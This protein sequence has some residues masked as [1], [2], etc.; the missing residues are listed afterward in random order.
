MPTALYALPID[1]HAHPSSRAIQTVS[2]RANP[3]TVAAIV[4]YAS[5]RS[6]LRVTLPDLSSP[7]GRPCLAGVVVNTPLARQRIYTFPSH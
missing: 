6:L 1:R 3:L 7:Q 5:Q 2:Y 4:Y